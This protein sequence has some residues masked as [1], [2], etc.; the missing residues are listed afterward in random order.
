MI[1]FDI[2]HCK[3]MINGVRMFMDEYCIMSLLMT[4]DP[5]SI[6][7]PSTICNNM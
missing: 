5:D 6:K 3:A 4:Y 7:L 1:Y 2:L